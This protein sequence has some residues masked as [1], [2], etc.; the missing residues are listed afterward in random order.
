MA[1]FKR[2]YSLAKYAAAAISVF[3]A[4]PLLYASPVEESY[5]PS[6]YNQ[7]PVGAPYF[8]TPNPSRFQTPNHHRAS[9]PLPITHQHARYYPNTPY[10]NLPHDNFYQPYH[11]HHHGIYSQYVPSRYDTSHSLPTGIHR[12][13]RPTSSPSRSLP[14]TRSVPTH[15]YNEHLSEAQN[16]PPKEPQPTS[17]R[18]RPR[19]VALDVP[20]P[21]VAIVAPT[22]SDDSGV[23]EEDVVN[24][25]KKEKDSKRSVR[26]KLARAAYASLSKEMKK[27][28]KP[29]WNTIFRKDDTVQSKVQV[30]SSG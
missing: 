1:S 19:P 27:L 26:D 24:E 28:P 7:T 2:R 3:N 8:A 14:N 5:D 18:F 15:Y 9:N 16:Q 4:K 30:T 29:N 11:H 20:A 17:P 23:E 12:P 22:L 13:T 21:A 10:D 6:H 25:K